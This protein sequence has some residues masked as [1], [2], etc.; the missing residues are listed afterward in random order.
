[1]KRC[2]TLLALVTGLIV[3]GNA[4]AQ[5]RVAAVFPLMP[6]RPGTSALD[7]GFTTTGVVTQLRVAVKATS[8]TQGTLVDVQDVVVEQDLAGA[9][10]FHVRVPLRRALPPDA[11]VDIDAAPAS[12]GTGE[13]Q[14]A[15]FD[16]SS[17]PPVLPAGSVRVNASADL[18]HLVVVVTAQ[19]PV[20]HAELTL[21]GA[22]VEAL[23]S[24]HGSLSDAEAV[25]FA[26]VRR[27]VGRPQTQGSSQIQFV[28]PLLGDVQVPADG[29]VVADI[30][31]HDPY[32]RVVNGSAVEFTSGRAFDPLVALSVTPSPLLLSGGY[33]STVPVRVTGHFS[34][35]G[36][37]DLSG[38]LQGVTYASSNS[39]VFVVSSEGRVQARS[40]GTAQLTATFGGLTATATVMVDS[41]ADLAS[42]AV[43][44]ASPQ[45]ARVGG[46]TALRLEGTLTGTPVRHVDLS[47]GALGT[48]WSSAK[49]DIA[50]VDRDGRVTG[51]RPGVARILATHESFQAFADVEVKDG[52][53][54]VRLSVP[55]TVVAGTAFDLTAVATDDIGVAS[56]EFLV[57]G[58]P[59]G[60]DTEAP[61]T[62]RIQA[63]PY[64][65]ATLTLAAAVTD[66]GGQRVVG[67]TQSV[68]VA[69]TP[70]PSK[71]PVVIEL[72]APG[73]MLVQGLPQVLRV[74]SGAWT[75]GTL[76]TEDFQVA[77]FYL[78]DAFAGAV[79]LPRV[80]VREDPETGAPIPVPLWEMT[81]TPRQ[82]TAGSSVALRVEA[83]DRA[84][85]LV[86]SETLLVRVVA[87]APPLLT[88]TQPRGTTANAVVGVPFHVSGTVGDDGMAFGT[89][90]SL[91]VAG[92]TVASTRLT[93]AGG[94]G[95][96]S[97][98]DFFDLSWT[99]VAGD[100]GRS[101]Q[102]EVV[103]ID[104]AGQ[105]SRYAF[106]ASV[107][108][109]APPKNLVILTP[110]FQST[111]VGGST[112]TLTA[113]VEDEQ[114]DK[115][116][117]RWFVGGVA[118]GLSTKAPYALAYTLPGVAQSTVLKIAAEARDVAGL[119]TLKESEVFV[120]PDAVPPSVSF[121][122]PK[123]PAKVTE[124]QDLLVSVAGLD[125]VDVVK[126]E[127]LLDGNRILLDESP[128][129]NGGVRGSFVTHAVVP[130]SALGAAGSHHVLTA[131]AWD[132]S[133]NLGAAPQVQVEVTADGAPLVSFPPLTPTKATVGTM[134]DVSVVASDDV[135]VTSVKLL[136]DGQSL[137]EA[138]VPPYHFAFTA[139]GP[140]RKATLVARASDGTHVT[141]ASRELDIVGDSQPPM[142]TFRSP[143][144]GAPVFAGRTLDVVVAAL[145]DVEVTQVELCAQG[146]C[147]TRTTGTTEG[148]YQVYRWTV[149]V[150]ANLEGQTLTLR[151]EAKDSS[152]LTTVR[153]LPVAVVKDQAPVVTLV[154]P[155]AG[156]PYKEGEDVRLMATVGD[157]DGVVGFVGLSGGV[158]Q[159][160]LPLSGP[161]LVLSG[162]QT[163][164][165]QAPIISKGAQPSV[166][167]EASD[168]GGQTGKAEVHLDVR[169]DTEAPSAVLVAP[170][171]PQG[172]TLTVK[173]DGALGLRVEAG[174]D[175][176][177]A[178]VDVEVRR[179]GVVVSGVGGDSVLASKDGRYEE[180]RT[181]NPLA[182]GEIL[183]SRRYLAS[184]EGT[185]SLKNLAAGTDYTLVTR[186]VDPAGNTTATAPL[187]FHIVEAQDTEAPV[188]AL[189]LEGAPSDKTCVAGSQ[190]TLKAQARDDGKLASLTVK[191]DGT[192]LT[193]APFEPVASL[194]RTWPLTLPALGSFGPRTYTF[195]AQVTDAAG[196]TTHASL[197]CELVA[198]VAPVV[199]WSQPAANAALLEEA[200][201]TVQ[202]EVEEDT[203]LAAGWL[204][205]STRA[206][207]GFLGNGHFVLPTP[208]ASGT[209]RGAVV[210]L[211][212]GT[213]QRFALQAGAT[214]LDVEPPATGLLGA[215]PRRLV[216]SVGPSA[217]DGL[218]AEVRYRF[219]VTPGM[220]N[221]A[222]LQSFLAANP[223]GRR[224]VDL[225]SASRCGGVQDGPFCVDL[226]FPAALDMEEVQVSLRP[227]QSGGAMPAVTEVGVRYE[228]ASAQVRAVVSGERLTVQPWRMAVTPGRVFS[229]QTKY[230]LPEGWSPDP[231]RLTVAVKDLSGAL[232]VQ[233]R[234]FQ[235]APDTVGPSVR[236]VQPVSGTSR[237]EKEAFSVQIEAADNVDVRRVELLVDGVSRGVREGV[238]LGTVYF[239][240][241]IPTP[242]TGAPLQLVALAEDR[243]GNASVSQ[244]VYLEIRPDAPPTVAL[245]QMEFT[246]PNG[247]P[248]GGNRISETELRSGYVRVLEDVPH[249]VRVVA[250]DDV[251]LAKVQ[252]W[253]DDVEVLT[254]VPA[255]GTKS[256]SHTVSF[257]PRRKAGGAPG[258]LR[259]LVTDSKGFQ[260]QARVLVEAQAPRAPAIAIATPTPGMTLTEGSVSLVLS[261]VAGDDTGV[262]SVEFF[263]NG[264]SALTVSRAQARSIQAEPAD[265]SPGSLPLAYDPTLR[266]AAATLAAPFN[267]VSRLKEFQGRVWLPPG[268]VKRDPLNP[269]RLVVRAVARDLENHTTGVEHGVVV[270]ADTT[271]PEAIVLRPSLGQD[272]VE[273]SPVVI[274]A[275]GLD[276]VFVQEVEILVGPHLGALQTVRRAGGFTPE[277]A[278]VQEGYG[279]SSPVVRTEFTAPRL[280]EL[281][282]GD[283]APYFIVV[284]V[285]DSA[286]NMS[287]DALQL[288]DIVRDQQPAVSLLSPS[289]GASVVEGTPVTVT[290]SAEDDVA[291]TSVWL[292]VNDAAYGLVLRA[293]PYVFNVPVPAGAATMKL[294]A[295][296][297]DSF[298]HEVRSQVVVVSVKQDAPPTVAI[299]EPQNATQVTEG[300]DFAFLVAAQDDVGVQSVE[301][302][303]EGGLGG[304]L[305][306]VSTSAPHRFRVPLPPGSAGRTLTLSASARDTAQKQ[307]L[308]PVVTVQV[309]ADTTPPTLSFLTPANNSE[310]T[311]G[312][313]LRVEATADDNVAVVRVDFK[314]NDALY[315]TMPAAPYAFTYR[316]PAELA[317]K[318]LKLEAIATDT[319]GLPTPALVTVGVKKDAPPEVAM[320]PAGRLVVGRP[321]PLGAT[322]SDDVAIA[323]VGFH[324]SRAGGN[325]MEVG[326]RNQ[327][328]YEIVYVP[329]PEE[330][331]QTVVFR[332]RAVDVAG[333]EKWS[334]TVS[335]VVE[336]DSKPTVAIV[337]PAAD[338]AI[339]EGASLRI[340]VDARDQEARVSAVHFFVDGLKV[341]TSNVPAGYAGKPTVFSATFQP[342]V[343]SGNRFL[344]LT[345]VAVDSAGQETTSAPVRV[346]TV[347]DTV[348]PEVELVDPP[349][350]DVVTEGE[351]MTLSAAAVDNAP[352]L[353]R[354]DFMLDG[355]VIASDTTPQ[356]GPANRPL[357]SGTWTPPTGF[358]GE[359]A[360]FHAVAW[361]SS[362]NKGVSSLE[363]V[364]LG[365]APS[366]RFIPFPGNITQTLL[367]GGPDHLVL[368][369]KRGGQPIH[370]AALTR[371]DQG[372]TTSLGTVELDGPARAA[373]FIGNTAVIATGA[374]A[375]GG[376]Q[377]AFPPQLTVVDVANPN[378]PGRKGTVDLPGEAI[379]GAAA[380]GH[381]A[382][383]ANGSAGV[384]VVD[385]GDPMTPVR[386]NTRTVVGTAYDVAVS[387]DLLLVAAGT[388][389][390]RVLDLR[391]PSLVQRGFVALPG[392]A[393][394]VVT[395]GSRAFV[396]CRDSAATLAVVDVSNPVEPLLQALVPHRS[397]RQDLL[398][399]GLSDVVVEGNLA[400]VAASLVKG[401]T[402]VKGLLTAS[403][404]GTNGTVTPFVRA[405][406]PSA[407][408]LTLT[409]G[410]PVAQFG[411]EGGAI[412]T[413]PRFVVT[414]VTPLDG[415][416]GVAVNAPVALEF[417]SPP[418]ES[419]V[420]VDTVMLR[421]ADPTLGRRVPVTLTA[422]GRSVTLT[423]LSTEPLKVSTPY[424]VVV[425]SALHDVAGR[426]LAKPFVS[427]FRTRATTQDAPVV[428][429]VVPAA[430]PL[431]GGSRVTLTGTHF[432][433]GAKV[434][435]AGAEGQA[436][437]VSEDGASL[438]VT[439]P[440][441]EEGPA[442]V[443]VVNPDGGEGSLVGGFLYLPMLQVS[444]VAPASGPLAGGTHVEVSGAG[445]QR[446]A[447]VTF[448]GVEATAVRV[449]APGRLEAVTPPGAFGPADVVVTNPDTKQAFAAG[450]FLY[451]RLAV[452]TRIGRYDPQ[453][454][455]STKPNYRL[456]KGAP[457]AVVVKDGTAWVLSGAQVNTQGL[458][459]T[460]VTDTS[461][462]GGLGAVDVSLAQA[463]VVGGIDILAPYEPAALAVR[464]NRAY[465]VANA[466]SL[467]FVDMVGEGGPS[468]LAFDI[469]QR[470]GPTRLGAVPFPGTARSIA[471]VGD[472]ALVAAG[473]GGLLTFSLVDKDQPLLLGA[474]TQFLMAGSSAPVSVEQVAAWGD[475]ALV[476]VKRGNVFSTLLLDLAPAGYAVLGELSGEFG[477]MAMRDTQSL[478]AWR[479]LRTTSLVPTSRPYTQAVVP[480]M[481][482][483]G[484]FVSGALG[485]Q[486]AAAVTSSIGMT[487]SPASL[488][489]VEASDL[490]TPRTI[491]AIDLYPATQLSD[492][493]IEGDVA[494]V[495]IS[496]T[497]RGKA[498][499]GLAVVR[500]PFPMVV[501][502]VPSAGE[503]AARPSSALRLTFNMPVEQGPSAEV[504][505]VL[506]DGSANGANV[507]VS[508]GGMG[509]DELTISPSGGT[510]ATS[511]RYRLTVS[512]LRS[513]DTQAAMPG[514]YTLEFGTAK[515]ANPSPISVTSLTPRQGPVGGG[516]EV[517]VE[518]TGF[519]AGLAVLVNGQ[520]LLPANVTLSGSTLKLITPPGA[521][522]AATLEIRN[523][524]G[525]RFVLPGAFV[526]T[527]DLSLVS[528]SPARGPTA[529][530]TRVVLTGHGFSPT[531]TV[532]VC[533]KTLTDCVN[534][535]VLGLNTLEATTPNGARGTVDVSVVNPDGVH[536]TL[537]NAFTFDQPTG[538]SV[539]LGG[540]LRDAVVIGSYAYV[541]GSTGLTVVDMSGLYTKGPK[542]DAGIAIP[543]QQ[544]AELVDE[545]KLGGDDRI[546]G[547]EAAGDL[548][549]VSY[550]STGGTRIFAS[551]VL[552]RDEDGNPRTGAVYEFDVS[553]PFQPRRVST[554]AIPGDG[555]YGVDARGDRLL[556]AAGTQGFHTFDISYAP[557]PIRSDASTPG[558]QTLSV[559][560]GQAAAGVGTR[561]SA[562]TVQNGRLRMLS[563][564]GPVTQRGE[565]ALNVQRVRL[566]GTLAAVA[567]GTEGLVLVDVSD[568]AHPVR[569]G[570]IDVKGFATDV[571]LAGDLAY[572]AAGA[573]GVAVVDI[574]DPASPQLRYHVTGAQ[575]GSTY[576]AV[577]TPGGRVVSLR[578][579]NGS[580]AWSVDFGPGT[581]LSVVSASVA[582]GDVVPLGLQSVT[583]VL[584]STVDPT[585]AQTAFQLTA[586][587][588]P[589]PGTLAAGDAQQALSTMVFTLA[590]PLPPDAQMR[591]TVADTLH[592][593]DGR[594]LAAPLQVDFRTAFAEGVAPVISQ[595]VPRV[596]PVAG[597]GVH[598]L[599]GAN[600]D[601]SCE[602]FIGGAP[603]TVGSR[604]S[605]R[606]D[607][608]AP[609]GAPGLADVV[610]RSTATGLSAR[611]SGG[612]FYT[613][614]LQAMAATP[615][616]LNP[617]GGSTVEVE[618]QGF[619]PP[620][621]DPLGLSTQVRVR[622]IPATQ[623]EVLS[624]TQLKA[625]APPGSFGDA[626]VMVLSSDGV[627][628][629]VATTTRTGYGLPYLGEEPA[630]AVRPQAL[631]RSPLSPFYVYSAAGAA[632]AGNRFPQPYI[633]ALT[634]QGTVPQ[635]YRAV[636]Y[637]VQLAGRPR[638]AGNQIVKAPDA[639]VDLVMAI[640]NHFVP[641]STPM[642]DIELMPDS[643]DIALSGQQLYVASGLSGLA[644]L[645]GTGTLQVNANGELETLGLLGRA[646]LSGSGELLSTRVI[647]TPVGAW[648]L[649][650]GLMD[651]P[652]SQ[653]PPTCQPQ[654]DQVGADGRLYLVDTRTPT[655]PLLVTQSGGEGFEP[656]GATVTDGRLYVVTGQH[657][658]VRYTRCEPNQ[659]L[660]PLPEVSLK[661][662]ARG[663]QRTLYK[664]N[665][666]PKGSLLIYSSAGADA[667]VVGTLHEN[668]NLTDVVVR[669]GVAILASA[670]FGLTFV[671]VS[672]PQTPSVITRIPFD[673]D[674][675]NT[676][677]EPQRLRL[678]GDVLFVAANAGGVV[679]VDVSDLHHPELLSGGNVEPA[680]DVLPVSDRLMLAGSSRLYE[681]ETPFMLVTG[682]QPARGEFVP[683][684]LQELVV[685]M[686]RPV[687]PGSVTADSVR[688][689]GPQGTNV[690]L[691]LSVRDIPGQIDFAIVAVPQQPLQAEALYTL[692][693]D[694]SVTDQ[695]G[696]ALLL[697]L[698]TTFKTA[699]AGARAPLIASFSPS[700]V[701]T[702]GG[703][704]VTVH[705][706]G[707]AGVNRV[708]LGS[709]AEGIVGDKTDTTLKV[710]LPALSAGPVDVRLVDAGGPETFFPAGLLALEPL[711]NKAVTLSPNHG[712]VSGG[713]RVRVSVAGKA[714]APGTTVK[715]G[716]VA[717]VDVDILDLSS[718]EFTTPISDAAGL[719]LVTL[720][721]P[722]DKDPL[723]GESV[724]VT[725]GTFSYDLP[726]GTT[727]S[728]PGFPPREA[729]DIKLVGDKL[730]VG[731]ST[732]SLAGL[733]IFDV[734]LEERPLRLGGLS[735]AS[736]VRGL[737]VAGS[738]ALLANDV[739]GLAAV[740]VS[741]P[742]TPFLVRR[743]ATD[744]IATSV[745]LE[746]TRA[747]VTT[748]NPT[749]AGGKVQVFDAA[750]PGLELL[751]TVPLATGQLGSDALALDLGPER[752]YVLTSDVV[753]T[754]GN[755]LVLSIRDRAGTLLGH[756]SVDAAL[757]QFED[758]VRSRVVVRSQRAY[759]TAGKRLHV[760]DLTNESS[761]QRVQSTDLGVDLAGLGWV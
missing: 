667:A 759:V 67:P 552:S 740:D 342:D 71:Q 6:L 722:E 384:A 127:I 261:A 11:V 571:R 607:V 383:V 653:P 34:L 57:N 390:L 707:L 654:R 626:P 417:S 244:T 456:A 457:L 163:L 193:V 662:G 506:L 736:P 15:H 410:T 528:I 399:T 211:E 40:D 453:T 602:V 619:L 400:V 589:V 220:E 395:Q 426:A 751:E 538:A 449:L 541:V 291:V 742:E 462:A 102:V 7:L 180:T 455:G 727:L 56:V 258:L 557:F 705:G 317:G 370:Q 92:T 175:V 270:V 597:G 274:E 424:F 734:R 90:V 511:Q 389:G 213:A 144:P 464:G 438:T 512:G 402:P 645:N 235:A 407:G 221:D 397:A 248:E 616:F 666:I 689:K 190:V 620:W 612:Y 256:A 411:D 354:V 665:V 475:R 603:A 621:A 627:E 473:D 326:R 570:D 49:P 547:F 296:A 138:M 681:L 615:R 95:T 158:R 352:P 542:A 585:S 5:T 273:G 316:V 126:A 169:A 243:S 80:E 757:T 64:G 593:R 245:S 406:L 129:E 205:G 349:A 425:T 30:A 674:L 240:L 367:R 120:V 195:T 575:A 486:V 569:M 478:S 276:N 134:V 531:G 29:V 712:P 479:T 430:G 509:T 310:I 268:F 714:V 28:V 208:N 468:L 154:A 692:E 656:Y 749:V 97:G 494:V 640:L 704:T 418:E 728:L 168:T 708:F 294:Q 222:L 262:G 520:E 329:Q 505:L 232:T 465:V 51:V 301:A 678:V 53:P 332:A 591:L 671:D 676:P 739:A 237:V 101:R 23:R 299:A 686:N 122:V 720:T 499:D 633:G 131:R 269:T 638:A 184:F 41:G 419:E 581:D 492:V 39:S 105:P 311:A 238:R 265:G 688:L 151:A 241:S 110:A 487:G 286:G 359:T 167:I 91:R 423:P 729:S 433:T 112:V 556:A 327:L 69:G 206:L 164:V 35:A 382:F 358:A 422:S 600:F 32:G 439:T 322:A 577:L 732:P 355:G 70:A 703:G 109:D 560:G 409:S 254:N 48:Q 614:P 366:G 491:D 224:Q 504:R 133:G 673:E 480:P 292:S 448:N 187:A 76:S 246:L 442:L 14:H 680:M 563:V 284:R 38:A 595:L 618:G 295:V 217:V 272:L 12:G 116:E 278:V 551:G 61:Y 325:E 118:V 149:P 203:G 345:A 351:P 733:E 583:V 514:V 608:V 159:G 737:D 136:L 315:A 672:N 525:T 279:L 209:A 578:Q 94:G 182:P 584:S 459:P 454:D 550:P 58:V 81:F 697:P 210:A 731:V 393:V 8:A 65:G 507:T 752:F 567:A 408:G 483:G 350:F 266:D 55:S 74:T 22:S 699:K 695:R 432:V 121:V 3:A 267:D 312:Q 451:S 642:P 596:G 212:F 617:R 364:E 202:V 353:A 485:P 761:P 693:V 668:G 21:V 392:E 691:A 649:T 307:A 338:T 498:L 60:K 634:G 47:A 339:F 545:D 573:A 26:S 469:S 88:V 677:G 562:G 331:G 523:P 515:V 594:S 263:I 576:A 86:R 412:Y 718:L 750:S 516:T 443:T 257:T 632:G 669:D 98:S 18:S 334:Q 174:D 564:E 153:E 753:G 113:Q 343:G 474:R 434:Y 226:M 592:S 484:L 242:T 313:L 111:Q 223:G 659:P 664:S 346:G 321:T 379:H 231:V 373:A 137:G 524:S 587:G 319:S 711:A 93:K 391:S 146:N 183:V 20:S 176:R 85:A 162:Q 413:L 166:G 298:D 696:G 405:N 63:P 553:N 227:I 192:A 33:G 701:S 471:L 403:V 161:P 441:R 106:T 463:G 755:G 610:V 641:A 624:L 482:R 723:T 196:R 89:Q 177:V 437:E 743:V 518:G 372:T 559:E 50:T 44:P 119:T 365:M 25:A 277:S 663:G 758:L 148:L 314:I 250:A 460:E 747:F 318:N 66:T 54:T 36:D 489:L 500:L 386:L 548:W 78:D 72:P 565:L 414:G 83:L 140:A 546:V 336:P 574:S 670:E 335:A 289:D 658:G 275:M 247:A 117:V 287:E 605:T 200:A 305:R 660:P 271:P 145:D 700:T 17:A 760:F 360:T 721:R 197:S 330:V 87:D 219:T 599:L 527:A 84:G 639:S 333:Q 651:P 348:P 114:P 300:R 713:T 502:S 170:L 746:G 446:G 283:S 604:S 309:V 207:A 687:S 259:V 630:L 682:T 368:V 579:R 544:Q 529:G 568:P 493:D 13:P 376:N 4:Q 648:V 416:Q 631:S 447:T 719:A 79:D 157:D 709:G 130:K 421:E 472:L 461:T 611:R 253:Y 748:V 387:G 533:F 371:V 586:D 535:K 214:G 655:D 363:T 517:T 132:S 10:P 398:A 181:P 236:I 452:S 323:S 590:A 420:T 194:T 427:G 637:D 646:K 580:G 285:R 123:A 745:R 173:R 216:L 582:T 282:A 716:G 302:T 539:A 635:S 96:S 99:P 288:V 73:A 530:G 77:R 738:L 588:V 125:D 108:A 652:D 623:V 643:L 165:V 249:K 306:F 466:Q 543:P 124:Q 201:Q 347:R 555:V 381:L 378:V 42:V 725:V 675:S 380:A 444:F 661:G 52:A 741:R 251:G 684:S 756:I 229:A 598:Q 324:A 396:A 328:P 470:N 234:A 46:M 293:P 735:T 204:V 139:T 19:G 100:L 628:R 152:N 440:A 320:A 561:T 388:G 189:S 477:A 532:K 16:L 171:S 62:L 625:V 128:G 178:R 572:V 147:V 215:A 218:R 179:N 683:P 536:A 115:V 501:A 609:S 160:P 450:A 698:R 401:T 657:Q 481:M 68:T 566:R 290:V 2:L 357:Y 694:T 156:T 1:M 142:L 337:Q 540:T 622:G 9:V 404:L 75:S 534:A 629:S 230:R 280:S 445:F 467:P 143:A 303:V 341:A 188:L 606:M 710:T 690:E 82:G 522:G 281:G 519:E 601:A 199:R 647:P 428:S 429:K 613:L 549:S 344:T 155:A 340:D 356:T 526:Y 636:A 726:I 24:V 150:A 488:Q 198:D 172:N 103:A 754:Q 43:L 264:K 715:V 717:G 186:A 702:A 260:Q 394:R 521:E 415:T 141:E 191:A 510:L 554:R 27:Q 385:I 308:A 252:A 297:R 650:N 679:M 361:D 228:G 497:E 374:Y 37:V 458:T 508:V 503:V 537:P 744:G 135:A 495:G 730:Y 513:K 225:T 706:H 496:A 490:S 436:V 431:G 369:G 685:R 558:A 239:P 435:F 233:G 724:P 375:P 104:S 45:V 377:S 31:V 59:A 304:T 644:V 185:L 255:A 107:V 362:D 476:E